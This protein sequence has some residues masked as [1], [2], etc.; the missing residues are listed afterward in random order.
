MKEM[1]RNDRNSTPVGAGT[2]GVVTAVGLHPRLLRLSSFRAL[3]MNVEE[4]IN[5][6]K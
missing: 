5:A 6:T 1:T 4:C 3:W 2:L